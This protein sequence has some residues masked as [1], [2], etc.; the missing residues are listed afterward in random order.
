MYKVD[1]L[2][3]ETECYGELEDSSNFEVV[4]EDEEDDGIWCDGNPAQDGGGFKTWEDV[5]MTLQPHFN[6]DILEICAV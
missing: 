6:S 1:F 5:V 4:C 3:I 2:G